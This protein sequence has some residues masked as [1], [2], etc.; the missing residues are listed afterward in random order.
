MG[1]GNPNHRYALTALALALLAIILVA[2]FTAA[3]E[4]Q[5]EAHQPPNEKT[6]PA[7]P[8][9]EPEQYG[10]AEGYWWPQFS[11]RDTYAQWIM[12]LATIAATAVSLWAVIILNR[13]LRATA[14]GVSAAADAAEAATAANELFE[15]NSRRELR[16]YVFPIGAILVGTDKATPNINIQFKNTGVT[17]A[18]RVTV[19]WKV[20]PTHAS[21]GFD[22]PDTLIPL[23][24]PNIGPGQ[25]ITISKIVQPS[26]WANILTDL[27]NPIIELHAFGTLRYVDA[28]G[29][30]HFTNF[31]MKVLVSEGKTIADS[32]FVFCNG[33]NDS[34]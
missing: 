25:P 11:A 17:P 27:Q 10:P 3:V 26:G 21:I 23:I 7:Y 2:F 33:G 31:R 4:I 5:R 22:L 1:K 20:A 6:K 32:D 29:A 34:D 13:T 15:R 16:A 9:Y 28:F 19:R 12:M 18:Y 14:V 30:T 24:Q 8:E